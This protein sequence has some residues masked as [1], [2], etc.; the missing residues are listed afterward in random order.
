MRCPSCQFDNPDDTQFCGRCGSKLPSAPGASPPSTD[1]L[2]I[3]LRVLS[4][5]VVF[6]GR[7][8]I[9]E[10]LGKGGM[11]RVYKAI[12]TEIGETVAIKLLKP[13]IAAD[14]ATIERFRNELRLARQISHKSVCRMYHLGRGQGSYYITMEY[15]SGEDLK[16]TILRVG[17]LSVVRTVAIMRQVC[18]GLAE[19]HRLGVVHRDLKP[20]NIMID[21]GGNAKIMDFGIARSITAKDLTAAGVVVG[22]PAYMSPEQ[23]DGGEVDARGDIYALGIILFEMLTGRLPFEGETPFSI[24]YKQKSEL[25]PDPRKINPQVPEDLSALILKCLAKDKAARYQSADDVREG[26]TGVEKQLPTTERQAAQAKSSVAKAVTAAFSLKKLR[27]PAALA[28]IA[29]VAAAAWLLL[30][31]RP[32][33]RQSIAVI[34][35]KNQTGD[36]AYDYL[37]DA[38][39]NLLIT[40]LEQSKYLSVMTWERTR[41]LLKQMNRAD[42]AFIDSDLGFEICR[43]DAVGAIV[44]GSFVKAGDMF[45]TDVKVYDVGT[46]SVLK[47]AKVQGVGVRS[48]LENQIGDLSKEISS[49]LGLSGLKASATRARVADLTTSSMEAYEYYLKGR[50]ACDKF[51]YDEARQNLEKAVELDPAFAVAYLQLA[52]AENALGDMQESRK[53]LEKS[54]ALSNKA[55]EK[56]RLYIEASYASAVERD[57]AKRYRILQDLAR[58]YPK[59]KLAHYLLGASD[60]SQERYDGALLELNQALTLDP[61]YGA[62]LNQIAYTYAAKGEYEAALERFRRY[63]ALFPNDANPLDSMGETYFLMGRL[64]EAIAKYGEAV[65]VR[66]DF[67]ASVA[68]E[69]YVYA[70]KEEY[71]KSQAW[72]DKFIELAP[73][74]A[75]KGRGLYAKA[76]LHF[77]TGERKKC[78]TE[79]DQL[80]QVAIAVGYKEGKAATEQLAAWVYLEKGKLDQCRQAIQS[81]YD[82]VKSAGGATEIWSVVY[83]LESGYAD[84]RE[85]KLEA[86]RVRLREIRST[87]PAIDPSHRR[88]LSYWAALYEGEI[89]LREGAPEKAA[90]LL[91]N[92]P[93]LGRPPNMQNIMGIYS[94][95]FPKDVLGRAY[96]ARGAIDKAIAEY[97]RLTTFDPDRPERALLDPLNHFRLAR[98]YDRR[99]TRE[100]AIVRY[101]RF[102]EL[103]KNADPDLP[104]LA[105]TRGRLAALGS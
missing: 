79:L 85:S 99:G 31:H 73:S 34:S 77:L 96:A 42:A 74:I 15:V 51:Y 11:G 24:A 10:D 35:F 28:A 101:R 4:V 91:E 97:E 33:L 14:A 37:Q 47:S 93:S 20:Q 84:L 88:I 46:K 86:A 27:L 2:E 90:A 41:D 55:T 25:P 98:L 103:W 23:V 5:G 22:T 69:S 50:D 67:S 48:I 18:E 76:F 49:G 13:E 6:G 38:I 19:A 104:E 71:D 64:D 44:L 66:P 30:P 95:L 62:A 80:I 36:K 39:P 16:S 52:D 58:K 40:S 53:A 87:I 9:V 21:R 56:E 60:H 29:L 72:L 92:A 57:P 7:Y 78:E 83:S 43:K 105:E 94:F 32:R 45:A 63:A 59:E 26:L 102:L 75:L 61:D 54:K 3:P 81:W 8:Q 12:D 70:L 89:L 1:T 65:S 82:W 17:P 100:Q 68:S